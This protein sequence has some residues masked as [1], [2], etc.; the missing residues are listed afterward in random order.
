MAA[1]RTKPLLFTVI[2]LLV[3]GIVAYFAWPASTPSPTASQNSPNLTNSDASSIFNKKQY[4]LSE[5]ESIWIIVNKKRPLNP[6]SYV[7]SD[8]IVPSVP[9]RV[10]GNE[11]MQVRRPVA[12]ALEKMFGAAKS[13]S[14]PLMLS[15]G[16]RSYSYQVSLYKGYVK[17]VGQSGA[18]A[19]SAR[20]GYSEHQ[21]GLSADIEPLDEK[22]DV[23]VCFADLPAGKWLA[24]N[25]YKFG[26]I[27]RYP[28]DKVKIT[29]YDY[30]PWH[31]RYVGSELSTEMHS[32][33]IETLEEFF[34]LP[35]APAY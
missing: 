6:V 1:L 27:M 28:A 2:F 5:P 14:A 11:S 24:A 33:H 8:L 13:D 21:T 32:K 25:A 18:D 17:S 34:N 26:F 4:S 30:E 22:C 15:S 10:P 3:L 19:V 16:Y 31:F 23:S 29:G 35:A 20:P 9:L 12:V 7:P